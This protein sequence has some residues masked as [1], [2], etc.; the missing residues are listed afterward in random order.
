MITTSQHQVRETPE[1]LAAAI[2]AA[3]RF[4]LNFWS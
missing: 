3:E 2:V 4:T 1:K